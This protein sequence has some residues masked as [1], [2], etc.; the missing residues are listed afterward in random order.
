MGELELEKHER[1]GDRE[2]AILY[3]EEF[4]LGTFERAWHDWKHPGYTLWALV[5]ALIAGVG[6]VVAIGVVVS[7]FPPAV[8]LA[9]PAAIVGV[10]AV[11][12]LMTVTG[13]RRPITTKRVFSYP[14]GFAQLGRD[15]PEPQVVRW[16]DVAEVTVSVTGM[17]LE[18]GFVPWRLN[19]FSL[20]TVTGTTLSGQ[21]TIMRESDLRAV[22]SAA[23]QSLA[24]RLLPAMT[25]QYESAGAVSFGR[26]RVARDGVTVPGQRGTGEL[27]PWAEMTDIY[28]V[29]IPADWVHKVVI[30]RRGKPDEEISVD[31]LPNGIFLPRVLAHAAARHR[32]RVIPAGI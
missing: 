15:E 16:E 14:N 27:I 11:S 9:V 30:H 18:D 28:L 21:A 17:Q 13:M 4:G 6:L 31:G 26:V 29:T 32:I 19:S 8:R 24:P 20:S 5:C 2:L 25:E 10:F 3:G 12:T 22:V 23:Y 1:P 7:P